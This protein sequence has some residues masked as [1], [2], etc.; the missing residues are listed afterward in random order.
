MNKILLFVCAFF[1]GTGVYAQK[2]LIYTDVVKVDST[3]TKNELYNRAKLWFT[4]TFKDANKVLQVQDEERGQLVGK[5]KMKYNTTI[6]AGSGTT[7]GYI[8][9]TVN[10]FVKDGR[11]KYEITDFIHEGSSNTPFNMG[12]ITDSETAPIF[13]EK[14]YAIKWCDKLWIDIKDQIT[15]NARSLEQS[16]KEAMSKPA[17]VENDNW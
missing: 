3:I 6:F 2:P 14:K 8:G 13:S 5:G 12:L 9:Y 15:P 17:V 1:I 11:Y 10:L 4:N 16:L 7:S